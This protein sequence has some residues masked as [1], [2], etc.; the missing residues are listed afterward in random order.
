MMNEFAR[1]SARAAWRPEGSGFLIYDI[2]SDTVS[3]GNP[4]GRLVLEGCQAGWSV[5]RI[6]D[7]LDARYDVGEAQAIEDVRHFLDALVA[8]D[9]VEWVDGAT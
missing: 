5:R 1:L 6:A 2:G 3:R 7:A 8:D 4:E 9:L